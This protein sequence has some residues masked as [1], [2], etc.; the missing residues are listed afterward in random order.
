MAGIQARRIPITGTAITTTGEPATATAFTSR[1]EFTRT[2]SGY[3]EMCGCCLR[4]S[5]MKIGRKSN[6][7]ISASPQQVVDSASPQTNIEVKPQRD[8]PSWVYFLLFLFGVWNIIGLGTG[9]WNP[10][11]LLDDY[12]WIEHDHE[13]PVWIK[14]EWLAG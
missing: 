13:T 10:Y 1:S 14:G 11:R 12:G 8:L 5:S 2:A 9:Y 6:L 4:A 3:Q 7:E